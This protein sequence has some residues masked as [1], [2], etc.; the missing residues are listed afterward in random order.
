MSYEC[1]IANI[2]IIKEVQNLTVNFTSSSSEGGSTSFRTVPPGSEVGDT[3]APPVS[4]G[5]TNMEK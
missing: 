1:L 5:N 4:P 3:T 2:N